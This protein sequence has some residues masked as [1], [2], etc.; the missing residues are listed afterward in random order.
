MW[1]FM[2]ECVV[3]FCLLYRYGDPLCVHGLTHSFP[4]RRA[5]D[6]EA[7]LQLALERVGYAY[8]GTCRHVRMGSQHLL[9][10]TGG[11][12]VARDVDHVV[13][14]RHD[15]DEIGRAHV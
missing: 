11:Q 2:I 6:L 7:Q 13:G 8:H 12:P 9:H 14:P 3:Y 4:T 5:A 10:G 15:V 1:W